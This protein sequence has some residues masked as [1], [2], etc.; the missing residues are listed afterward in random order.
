M[1]W[2]GG[3]ACRA[4]CSTAAAAGAGGIWGLKERLSWTRQQ[5]WSAKAE[6]RAVRVTPVSCSNSRMQQ[7]YY[8]SALHGG[9]TGIHRAMV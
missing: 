9:T 6:A 7:S 4:A 1:R 3:S 8:S 2:L 5:C